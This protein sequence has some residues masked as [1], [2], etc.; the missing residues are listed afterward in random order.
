M[1]LLSPKA[2]SFTEE[3]VNC[4]HLRGPNTGV[5][6]PQSVGRIWPTACFYKG[7]LIG[8]QPGSFIYVLF[9]AAFILQQL[10]QEVAIETK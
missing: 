4:T 9:R 6:R 2:V 8:A 5:G 3:G 1:F 7:S 10:Y